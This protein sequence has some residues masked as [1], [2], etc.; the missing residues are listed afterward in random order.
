L[1]E[2]DDGQGEQTSEKDENGGKVPA[3]AESGGGSGEET[4]SGQFDVKVP[5]RNLSVAVSAA[6]SKE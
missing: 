6:T 3:K 1:F 5:G 2:I 4:P